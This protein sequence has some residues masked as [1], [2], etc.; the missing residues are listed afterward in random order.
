MTQQHGNAGNQ[1]AA[2]DDP[3]RNRSIYL[4]DAEYASLS[5]LAK[6]DGVNP[7]EW[8]RRQVQ[9]ST[10]TQISDELWPD[11]DEDTRHG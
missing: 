10:A 7:S 1:N 9:R 3:R 6:A 11:V 8:V 4:S 2:V 5:A